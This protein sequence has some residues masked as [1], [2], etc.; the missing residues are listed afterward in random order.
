LVTGDGRCDPR[1]VASQRLLDV[2]KAGGVGNQESQTARE[3]IL[4]EAYCRLGRLDEAA[5]YLRAALDGGLLDP[6]A[7]LAMGCCLCSVAAQNFT[8]R[9]PLTGL[10]SVTDRSGY[11]TALLEAVG[12]LETGLSGGP[13]DPLLY[14]WMGVA[15]SEA[16]FGEASEVAWSQAR[17]DPGWPGHATWGRQGRP[18]GVDNEPQVWD[19]E[20]RQV[21]QALQG[22]F[23]IAEVQGEDPGCR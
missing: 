2:V 9:D 4:A 22:T 16:G 17:R 3:L 6:V 18:E 11:R 19:D 21:A 14:W 13:L 1:Q 7:G 20:S 10:L 15:L 23:T 12:R 8:R 5:R